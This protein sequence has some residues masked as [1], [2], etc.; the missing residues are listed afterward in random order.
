[1]KS[2]SERPEEVAN[3]LNPAFCGE[4]IRRCIRKY[5]ENTEVPFQYS[6]IFLIL[7]IVLHRGTREKIQSST[8]KQMHVWIQEN[9]KVRIGFAARAKN[10]VP[11]TKETL[12]FLMQLKAIH[13]NKDGSIKITKYKKT[14]LASHNDGEIADILKKAETI[15]KWFANAG[16]T[17]TIYTMWGVKP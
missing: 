6:L 17:S 10:L 15:G 2:W 8:R 3:L 12:A 1:M 9:Q 5:Y 4:I 11:V 16:T 13:I 14:N 7:P